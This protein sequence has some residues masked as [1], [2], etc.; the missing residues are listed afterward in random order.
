L[1]FTAIGDLGACSNFRLDNVQEITTVQSAGEDIGTFDLT[2]DLC[3]DNFGI[4]VIDSLRPGC[5]GGDGQIRLM[6]SGDLGEDFIFSVNLDG[7]FIIT[8]EN[9]QNDSI[10][11]NNLDAG[12]YTIRVNSLTD[13]SKSETRV[14]NLNLSPAD[15]PNI[16]L[17][18]NIDAGCV[19]DDAAISI[20]L[21]GSNFTLPQTSGSGQFTTQW[22][23]LGTGQLVDSTASRS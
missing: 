22:T 15:L 14:F 18:E 23:A 6:V 16:T 10:I 4:T 17:D 20:N 13:V 3:I 8:G 5:M 19:A 2:N 11:L 21:D 7:N 9:V 12:E 1:C